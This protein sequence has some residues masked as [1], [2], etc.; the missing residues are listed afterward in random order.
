MKRCETLEDLMET[1]VTEQVVE[2]LQPDIRVW[3]RE[4]KPQ[5]G[6]EAG[7][8][9]DDHLEAPSAFKHV[10]V[11]TVVQAMATP[12]SGSADVTMTNHEHPVVP[13]TRK[14]F[15]CGEVGHIR[16][17]CPKPIKQH[18]DKGILKDEHKCFGCG[19]KGH[20]ASSC[21]AQG[22]LLCVWPR[23]GWI[24]S[25]GRSDLTSQR[26]SLAR[27]G[28]GSVKVQ[29]LPLNLLDFR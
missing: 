22:A 12:H 26:L 4:R 23:N 29:H 3:V 14:C 9:A 11:P 10:Y 1:L 5:T 19:E 17:T 16:S 28:G 27:E 2:T 24:V 15:G 6:V 18:G 25:Q 7:Q 13:S 8:L 21:P 20:F